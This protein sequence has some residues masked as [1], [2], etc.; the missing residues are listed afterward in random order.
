MGRKEV[1]RRKEVKLTGKQLWERGL[2][3]KVEEDEEGGEEEDRD[4]LSGVESL[5]FGE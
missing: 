4:A 1:E 3:G 5:K 2:V